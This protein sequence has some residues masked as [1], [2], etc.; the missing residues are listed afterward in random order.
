MLIAK[1]VNHFL[2]EYFHPE[3]LWNKNLFGKFKAIGAVISWATI[4]I[5]IIMGIGLG[6]STLCLKGK[7][8]YQY[9]PGPIKNTHELGTTHLGLIKKT[10]PAPIGDL[11]NQLSKMTRENLS[12]GDH[13]TPEEVNHRFND[14][15][16]PRNT[17]VTA[18]G[19]F[20]HANH[21]NIS[22]SGKKFIASQSPL[23]QDY[24][25]FWNAIFNHECNIVDLT[26]THD[27]AQVGV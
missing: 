19:K 3:I 4:I 13:L 20:L 27:R 21:V 23:P 25:L 17:A 15:P 7:V 1:T 9:K 22:A 2:S 8:S 26:N 18:K 11:W 24:E 5:P 6:I 12:D 14:V 16:S 10:I